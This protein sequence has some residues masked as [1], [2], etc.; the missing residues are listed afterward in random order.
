MD[1]GEFTE[2][3]VTVIAGPD[4]F[5]VGCVDDA[6]AAEQ[7]VWNMTYGVHK[8]MARALGHL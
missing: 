6:R 1:R 3:E 5:H 8:L 2:R 4:V 7:A